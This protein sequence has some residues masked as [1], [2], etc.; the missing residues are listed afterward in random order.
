MENN[1]E[2]QVR[3]PQPIVS[4]KPRQ[5]PKAQ[6]G[7]QLITMKEAQKWISKTDENKLKAIQIRAHG[8]V[9]KYVEQEGEHHV[10]RSITA[11]VYADLVEQQKTCEKYLAEAKASNNKEEIKAWT[12]F[13]LTVL[14]QMNTSAKFMNLTRRKLDED[15]NAS[16]TRVPTM[17]ART[18]ITN[19]TQV[20]VQSQDKT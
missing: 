19:N 17:P 14:A 16:A 9:G 6:K 11:K 7:E 5:K 1:G 18:E 3:E 10:A 4:V 8:K 20:I 13:S 2:I 12:D 15:A